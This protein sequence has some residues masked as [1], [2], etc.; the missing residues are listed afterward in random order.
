MLKNIIDDRKLFRIMFIVVLEV[1]M[2]YLLN[3]GV[4]WK[5]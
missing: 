5:F 3:L 2:N 4:K 1:V